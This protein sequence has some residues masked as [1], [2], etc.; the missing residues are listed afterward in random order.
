MY[1]FD[2]MS[3][4]A[5]EPG[6]ADGESSGERQDSTRAGSA[7][8]HG[9]TLHVVRMHAVCSAFGE[10]GAFGDAGHPSRRVAT[11]ACMR[12]EPS[13]AH[14]RHAGVNAAITRDGCARIGI[15]TP[16]RPAAAVALSFSG[17]SSDNDARPPARRRIGPAR[18]APSMLRPRR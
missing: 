12:V 1:A 6:H 8:S 9:A 17:R 10:F 4:H 16:A 11:S 2:R 18:T 14:P 15:A 5:R 13:H 7:C 3:L